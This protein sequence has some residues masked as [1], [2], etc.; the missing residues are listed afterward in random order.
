[1]YIYPCIYI[2]V[3]ISMYISMYIYIH[4]YPCVRLVDGT[5]AN[6]LTKTNW[7]H[8]MIRLAKFGQFNGK[9]EFG[10]RRLWLFQKVFVFLKLQRFSRLERRRAKKKKV[11]I[12]MSYSY[13]GTV[14]LVGLKSS[15]FKVLCAVC[16]CLL[17]TCPVQ[18]RI[19]VFVG[20]IEALYY[21]FL[22]RWSPKLKLP[23]YNRRSSSAH[24][25][26]FTV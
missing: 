20:R 13:V 7:K 11:S 26:L 2:H 18:G 10:F 12:Q 14:G 17:L 1:M 15:D 6:K 9:L 16:T 22:L 25:T 3:Y 19:K 21:Y 23:T 4:V 8:T 5:C 24:C